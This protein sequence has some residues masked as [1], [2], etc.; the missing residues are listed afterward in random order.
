MRGYDKGF[1]EEAIKLSY[2]VGIRAAAEQLGVPGTTVI[3]LEKSNKT[4]WI[5]R[6][7]REWK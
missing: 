3:H 1:K 6:F 5:N 2:E 4:V 7:C